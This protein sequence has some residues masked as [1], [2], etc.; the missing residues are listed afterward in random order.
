MPMIIA[1]DLAPLFTEQPDGT[2]QKEYAVFG[3]L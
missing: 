3:G 1:L 2:S